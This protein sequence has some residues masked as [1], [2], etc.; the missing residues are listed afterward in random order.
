MSL[1]SSP[2]SARDAV[3]A[4]H[5]ILEVIGGR[6]AGVYVPLDVGECCIGSA[7]SADVV[8]RDPGVAPAHVRLR[9]DRS[10]LCIEAEGGDVGV[11][12]EVLPLGHGCEVRLPIEL[13][14]G[15][16]RLCVSRPRSA[17]IP[18]APF[19]QFARE[20]V[21]TIGPRRGAAAVML[22]AS[23]LALSVMAYPR[24]DPEALTRAPAAPG[25][26]AP[27][28]TASLEHAMGELTTRI[29]AA[30]LRGLRVGILDGGLVVS[31]QLARREH[32]AWKAIERWF[33]QSY[34]G[35][36]VLV[37]KVTMNEG[38]PLP[39][40]QLQAIWFG[41]RPY[42]IT[43]TGARHEP[44]SVLDNGWTLAEIGEGQLVFSKDGEKQVLT[45]P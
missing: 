30:R 19:A 41:V 14:L 7:H 20:L 25:G 29:D 35:R 12:D 27:M 8:L 45:F 21:E 3:P 10:I 26:A 42:I 34:G 9:L 40:P 6:H 5:L 23:L 33:D 44:G 36:L 18:D 11:G 13:A 39:L 24:T 28:A 16:A 31:G 38:R 15:E 22:V 2:P 37:S 4:D 1:P 17:G 32:E 43:A